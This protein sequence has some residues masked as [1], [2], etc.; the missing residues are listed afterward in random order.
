VTSLD[1]ARTRAHDVLLRSDYLEDA[2]LGR[3][4]ADARALA[5]CTLKVVDELEAER[6]ARVAMQVARDRCI[7]IL[8][9]QAGAALTRTAA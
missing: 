6:S 2:G 9:R 8:E 4:A 3:L 5:R 7:A 1:E